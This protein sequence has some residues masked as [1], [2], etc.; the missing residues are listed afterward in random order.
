MIKSTTVS[1]NEIVPL[2]SSL[3]IFFAIL[4]NLER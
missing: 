4:L 2:N 3:A 1:K